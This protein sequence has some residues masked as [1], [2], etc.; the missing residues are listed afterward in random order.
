[1]NIEKEQ[2]RNELKEYVGNWLEVYYGKRP[3]EMNC[4]SAVGRKWILM[5]L[6]FQEE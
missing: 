6:L 1:M 5:D 4:E 2:T 3:D